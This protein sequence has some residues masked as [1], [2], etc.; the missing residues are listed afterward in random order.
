M[1]RAASA[2]GICQKSSRS[3]L[4]AVRRWQGLRL[5]SLHGQWSS[6]NHGRALQSHYGPINEV[7]FRKQLKDE[8]KRRRK[9]EC[10][11]EEKDISCRSGKTEGAQRLSKWR[12][13]V[14]LEIHA[15]LNTERKLFST[16]KSSENDAPNTNISVFD[17]AFPGSQPELQKATLIPAIRAAFGLSCNIHEQSRFDRK[18]YYYHDQP[19]GYQITQ[20]YRPFAVDGKVTLYDYDGIAPEDGRFVDVG[21]K[22]VQ[23]E[24]DTAKTMLQ[25]P[26]TAMIDF[27]RIGHPLIEIITH[28]QIHHVQTASACIR[29]IQAILQAV[30]AV[31]KGMELG[32]LRADVNVS[33]SPTNSESLGQRTEIKNL[34]SFKAVECAIIAERDRQ[35]KVLESGASIVG[36][37]RGWTLGSSETKRLRGKEGEVDYRYMPDPDVLPL[38]IGQVSRMSGDFEASLLI[39]S[40]ELTSHIAKSI[41]DLPDKILYDL[42]TYSGLSAKDAKTLI[43]LDD[44]ERLD[45]FDE[46][47][48]LWSIKRAPKDSLVK[49]GNSR[50]SFQKDAVTQHNALEPRVAGSSPV[51]DKIVANWYGLNPSI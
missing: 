51:F 39:S 41:P 24:Q 8:A 34:S 47:K 33:V 7:P 19:A 31:T 21:I 42:I 30:N 45:Y 26:S 28:P 14:G 46:V 44:G 49:V 11:K 36:E 16:A 17:L 35:I 15:Q 37:T 6:I 22:Q 13:T 5:A 2:C 29:K 48:S 9:V 3:S 4:E 1:S 12:L 27:N 20:Y 32:G 38:I 18:H 23:M 40:Q 43:T 25:P 10:N 50:D